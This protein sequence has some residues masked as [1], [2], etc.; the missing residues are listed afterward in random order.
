MQVQGVCSYLAEL[1]TPS[2][3][4]WSSGVINTESSE[5]ISVTG[6]FDG[7]NCS[8]RYKFKITVWSELEGKGTSQITTSDQLGRFCQPDP[9]AVASEGKACFKVGD[10][11]QGTLS[12]LECRWV[13][14]QELIWIK[15]ANTAESYVN[16]RSPQSVELCKLKGEIEGNAILGFGQD[17]SSRYIP[18]TGINR[19]LIVPID[20]PDI[21]G[22]LNF[23][24]RMLDQRKKMIDW[25]NYYSS[26]R[27]DFQVDYLDNWVRTPLPSSEYDLYKFQGTLDKRTDEGNEIT[28]KYAQKYVDLITDKVNLQSYQTIY[29]FY[30]AAQKTM[31]DFVP[32]VQRYQIKEGV[33][34]LS[35]FAIGDY[36][37]RMGTPYFSF[38]LHETGHDWGLKGHSPG[39]GWPLGLM[40]NQAGFSLNLSGWDQFLMSWLP[41]DQVFCETKESLKPAEVRL[42][43]LQREDKQTKIIAIALDSNRLLVVESHGIDKWSS[44]RLDSQFYSFDQFGFYGVVAYVVNTKS[45]GGL[46]RDAGGASLPYDDGNNDFLPR[47]AKFYPIEGEASNFYGLNK[48]DN[49]TKTNDSFIAVEGDHFVIEGIK[50][51]FVKG[52]DYNTVRIEKATS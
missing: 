27:L 35:V 42:S 47:Q 16:P 24:E 38:W 37:I 48:W 34:V 11:V 3:K 29:I 39:D 25:V 6:R 20:F 50:I 18:P 4:K 30:P 12:Y 26:G 46:V 2:G 52:S 14:G 17:F 15:L 49:G 7:L 9:A 45:T 19:S 41:D 10:R 33:A 13:K 40:V 21:P 28:R 23:L 36:D 5:R 31:R 32:R 43:P 51:T 44:R 8:P 22:E 1:E